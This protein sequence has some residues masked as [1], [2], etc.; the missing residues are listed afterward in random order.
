MN[1]NLKRALRVGAFGI[2]TGIMFMGAGNIWGFDAL[3]SAGFGATGAV[4][5]L[6]AVLSFTYAGKGNVPEKDFDSAINEAIQ[7][8]SSKTKKD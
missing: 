3:S 8:V 4:L 1:K 6:L 7:E 2:G 5:G